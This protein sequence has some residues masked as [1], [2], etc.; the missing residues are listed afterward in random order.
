MSPLTSRFRSVAV[1]ICI[2][3][4][5]SAFARAQDPRGTIVGRVVDRSESVV[6]GARIQ[7]TNVETKVTTTV[8]TNDTGTFRVPFLIP[9]TYQLTAEMAGFKTATLENIELR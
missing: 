5:I 3:L 2:A 8:Q 4:L 9:G 1:I 6:V 7:V